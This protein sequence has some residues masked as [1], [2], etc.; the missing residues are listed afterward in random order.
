MTT[1]KK[2]LKM[3][4][5]NAS[6]AVALSACLINFTSCD[7]YDLDKTDPEG[8]GASIYSYL[9]EDGHYTNTIRLIDDLGQKDVLAKTGSKTLFVADDDAYARFFSNNK[10]GVSR[11]EQLSTSQKKLLLYGAMINNSYQLNSLS[12]VGGDNSIIEGACM[13]RSTAATIYDSVAVVNVQDLPNMRPEDRK[14]NSL[15]TRFADRQNVVLMNS[16]TSAPMVHF[17]EDFINNNHF[18]NSDIDFLFNGKIHRQPGDAIVNGVNV[19][20]KNIKCSNG[21]IQ[22]LDDVMLPL[23]NIAELIANNPRTS[24]FS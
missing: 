3:G 1:S 9:A 18:E 5:R 2:L 6:F 21:F 13:R 24:E 22:K 7:K 4:W 12:S 15:W 17:V 16:S 11:Y 20:Q 19:G 23:E 8:W 14:N 10:W